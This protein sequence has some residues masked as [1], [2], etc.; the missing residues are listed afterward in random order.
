MEF[1]TLGVRRVYVN[2]VGCSSE[3][4]LSSQVIKCINFENIRLEKNRKP[5]KNLSA[6]TSSLMNSNESETAVWG[7]SLTNFL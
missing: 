4:S 6:L 2:I 3:S 1:L 5:V 7:F